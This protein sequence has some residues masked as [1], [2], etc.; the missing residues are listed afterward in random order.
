MYFWI[1]STRRFLDSSIVLSTRRGR[2]FSPFFRA[3]KGGELAMGKQKEMEKE[4]E[5]EKEVTWSPALMKE[6]SDYALRMA[7]PPYSTSPLS[8]PTSYLHLLLY[9]L[10]AFLPLLLSVSTFILYNFSS[11][12]KPTPRSA[13]TEYLPSSPP[14]FSSSS[15]PSFP[16]SQVYHFCDSTSPY[17]RRCR[18]RLRQQGMPSSFSFS[19]LHHL[20]L[21]M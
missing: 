18:D 12:P 1:A 13:L 5:K 3:G 7:G 15:S 8:S 11:Y 6:A 21:L 9:S 4:K 10:C 16:S 2:C 14:P 19:F 20:H 17:P